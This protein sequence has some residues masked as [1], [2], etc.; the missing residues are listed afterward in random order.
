MWLC[1]TSKAPPRALPL[2]GLHPW[3]VRSSPA[4]MCY[5]IAA[6]LSRAERGLRLHTSSQMDSLK[7]L[8]TAQPALLV[9]CPGLMHHTVNS[10]CL[11]T[12]HRTLSLLHAFCTRVFAA[13]LVWVHSGKCCVFAPLHAKTPGGVSSTSQIVLLG[14]FHSKYIRPLPQS[15]IGPLPLWSSLQGGALLEAHTFYNTQNC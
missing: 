12:M 5:L 4:A 3:M 10:R 1:T 15:C 7:G 8:V 14:E 6:I 2:L 13:Q 9:T 11:E